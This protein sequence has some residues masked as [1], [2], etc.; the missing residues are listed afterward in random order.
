[1]DYQHFF[2]QYA[3]KVLEKNIT[4]Q[5]PENVSDFHDSLCVGF[6]FEINDTVTKWHIEILF[7]VYFD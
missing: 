3:G 7:G 5:R 6:D 4:N 2:L 1:M